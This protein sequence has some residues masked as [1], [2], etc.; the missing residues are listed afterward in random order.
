MASATYVMYVV[1]PDGRGDG[2]GQGGGDHEGEQQRS[3]HRDGDRPR[4]PQRQR[5]APE[6]S[7]SARHV[8]PVGRG[9]SAGWDGDRGREWLR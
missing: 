7:A 9:F 3:E 6:R 4:A 8:T 1:R 2:V 5:Q